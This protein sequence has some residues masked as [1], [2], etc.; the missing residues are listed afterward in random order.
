MGHENSPE[1]GG[2]DVAAP[3]AHTFGD[4]TQLF[5]TVLMSFPTTPG[6]CTKYWTTAQWVGVGFGGD[7]RFTL[8]IKQPILNYTEPAST[9]QVTTQSRHVIFS[10]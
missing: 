3:P 6:Q 10:G 9:Q 5:S 1:R 8:L 2:W 4:D 7:N